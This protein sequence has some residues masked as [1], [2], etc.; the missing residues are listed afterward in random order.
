MISGK[1]AGGSDQLIDFTSV[2]AIDQS[3]SRSWPGRKGP[4]YRSGPAIDP[5]SETYLI[6][7]RST[8]ADPDPGS[9]Y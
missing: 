4:S 8:N 5:I 9:Q 2:S 3:N 1:T 7:I 6:Q